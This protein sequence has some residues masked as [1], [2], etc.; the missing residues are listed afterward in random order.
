MS[1]KR[2]P[3]GVDVVF[4]AWQ[5]STGRKRT[6]LDERRRRLIRKALAVYPLEDVL[7]A[8]E[9]WKHSAHHRGENDRETVYND[10]GLLLR[11]GENVERFRDYTLG[12]LDA[13]GAADASRTEQMVAAIE[14]S[15]R[16]KELTDGSSPVG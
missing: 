11:N 15:P 6:V 7:A 1:P 4:A 14:G 16:R 12:V 9:G 13:H 2:K 5:E 8:V 3:S 10:L